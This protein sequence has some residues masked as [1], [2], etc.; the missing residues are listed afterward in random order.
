[1]EHVQRKRSSGKQMLTDLDGAGPLVRQSE[2]VQ[3]GAERSDYQR[4]P[5]IGPEGAHVS[6]DRGNVSAVG[7]AETVEFGF[8][9]G[10]H[11]GVGIKSRYVYTPPRQLKCYAPSPRA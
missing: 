9:P 11:I 4:E 5:S 1:M 3:K 2:I 8:E 10:Q 7:V 6:F